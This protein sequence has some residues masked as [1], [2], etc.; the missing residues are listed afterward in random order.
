M[1]NERYIRQQPLIGDKGQK[2]LNDSTV[3]VAG[4]GGLGSPILFH[5]ASAGIGNLRIVDDDIVNI[6]NLNRQ[7]LHNTD[8]IG[9]PKAASAKKTIEE[10]NPDI[11]VTAFSSPINEDT[12]LRLIGSADVIVDALD[13]FQTRYI[14]NEIA[15]KHDIPLI[16]GAVSGFTGHATLIIPTKTPCLSCIFPNIESSPNNIP[17]IGS[18]TGIIG[19]I[20]AEEVI[21]Y[22]TGIGQSLANKLLIWDGLKNKMELI[23]IKKKKDCLVCG[24]N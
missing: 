15:Y 16:H 11:N 20:E 19:S 12:I 1:I 17:I 6:S 2:I 18:T 23:S 9:I 8:R 14:L 10:F 24:T 4:C 5:L 13:N 3:F 7:F 21:K 22:L